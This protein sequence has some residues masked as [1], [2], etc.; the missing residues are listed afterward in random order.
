MKTIT[1]FELQMLIDKNRVELID[2]RPREEF[3][4]VHVLG[5]RSI[6]L[7]EFEPHSVL[8]H[9]KLDKHEPL[10]IMSRR[11]TLASLAVCGLAGA[12]LAEPIVVEGGLEAWEK[13]CLPVARK[14]SWRMSDGRASG[15]AARWSCCRSRPCIS[16]ILFLRR[17]PCFRGLGDPPC[18]WLRAS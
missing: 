8:A 18:F 15:D 4:K 14:Q 12:G 16:W 9:R 6:P 5:A 13:Q 11:K 10:Y 2:V 17:A 7:S 3:E 1:P